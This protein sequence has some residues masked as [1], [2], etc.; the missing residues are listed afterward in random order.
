MKVLIE[1]QSN[2]VHQIEKEMDLKINSWSKKILEAVQHVNA[3]TR[4]D[5]VRNPNDMEQLYRKYKF[6]GSAIEMI[7]LEIS[8]FN[9]GEVS[10]AEMENSLRRLDKKEEQCGSVV[11]EFVTLQMDES[12]V[13]K[14][15]RVWLEFQQR[16]IRVTRRAERF[17]SQLT[18]DE[19][20][21]LRSIEERTLLKEYKESN[22]SSN[23]KLPKLTLPEFH[24][25]MIEGLFLNSKICWMDI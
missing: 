10:K 20:A 11:Q 15:I 7:L 21:D 17:I 3:D 1:K 5:D 13:D 4:S 25:N 6:Y 24:G 22:S 19:E 14:E 8:E 2:F 16:I 9:Q 23:L 12:I 18:K